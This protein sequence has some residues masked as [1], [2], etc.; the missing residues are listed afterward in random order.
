MLRQILW[1]GAGCAEFERSCTCAGHGNGFWTQRRGEKSHKNS[2]EFSNQKPRCFRWSLL[3]ATNTILKSAYFLSE[4]VWFWRL[5]AVSIFDVFDEIFLE[6]FLWQAARR[7]LSTLLASQ[8]ESLLRQIMD[9]W[10]A[11]KADFLFSEE[12]SELR[13]RG[14]VSCCQYIFGMESFHT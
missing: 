6:S 7:V 12:A 4:S 13:S 8:L 10:R 14:T 2:Q 5:S 9:A 3:R 11:A 1:S